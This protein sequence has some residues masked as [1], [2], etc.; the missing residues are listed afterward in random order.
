MYFFV[1]NFIAKIIDRIY[2][3]PIIHF[4]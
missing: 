1:K 3:I 2:F 4:L